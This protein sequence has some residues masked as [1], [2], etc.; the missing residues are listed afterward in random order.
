M[1]YFPKGLTHDFGQ[2]FELSPRFVF[3]EK[4]PRN[5]VR[6]CSGKKKSRPTG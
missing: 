6:G 1:G 5:Y 3:I 2:K 4:R